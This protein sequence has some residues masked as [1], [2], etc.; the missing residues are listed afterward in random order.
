MTTTLT[1]EQF[2]IYYKVQIT[3]LKNRLVETIHSIVATNSASIV[4]ITLANKG[5]H[6]GYTN[7][8]VV[9]N[10]KVDYSENIDLVIGYEEMLHMYNNCELNLF[11]AFNKLVTHEFL[12]VL[13]G[14]FSKQKLTYCYN[15]SIGALED[16]KLDYDPYYSRTE[17]ELDKNGYKQINHKVY[18]IAAD[19][20]INRE[21][22]IKA[23]FLRAEDF[24]LDPNLNVFQYYAILMKNKEIMDSIVNYMSDL[25]KEMEQE[26]TGSNPYFTEEDLDGTKTGMKKV[27]IS[28]KKLQEVNSEDLLEDYFFGK[29]RG[30]DPGNLE[31]IIKKLK[32]QESIFLKDTMRV[33]SEIKDDMF[34]NQDIAVDKVPSWFK[35]N[36]RK[37]DYGILT[38]GKVKEKD[39]LSKNTERR[40]APIIFVDCSGS[41]MDILKELFYFLYNMLTYIS[42]TVV[43]YDVKVLKVIKIAN[44]LN[45]DISMFQAGGGTSVKDAIE[46][47]KK[48]FNDKINNVYIF[49]DGYD[50]FNDLDVTYSTVYI[51]D[52]D[53][54]K[55]KDSA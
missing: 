31:F 46:N 17:K 9:K 13:F 4:K 1:K 23:P 26:G 51:V 16:D 10:G 34:N 19:F 40:S 55:K 29:G 22:N 36:N 11:D 53:G 28:D 37:E 3:A 20:V 38:P 21:I 2:E 43:F 42:C 52:R 6:V 39:D 15:Y 18:N 32:K 12:H 30:F 25:Q 48:E 50:D 47:Y 54:I 7:E 27:P 33:I 24:D 14:D 5:T 44:A 49:T 35:Y 45:F 41:M 8:R